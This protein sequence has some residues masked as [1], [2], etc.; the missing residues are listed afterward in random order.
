Q[1]IENPAAKALSGGL[2]VGQHYLLH[3]SLSG[4]GCHQVVDEDVMVLTYP[5]EAAHALLES[6]ERPGDVPVDH[7]VGTLEVD[8]LAAGVSGHEDLEFAGE[9]PPLQLVSSLVV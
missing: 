8:A 1:E 4:V 6:H 7:H 9:K 5:V 2:N 3:P